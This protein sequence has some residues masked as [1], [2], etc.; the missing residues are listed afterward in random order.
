MP[1]RALKEPPITAVFDKGRNFSNCPNESIR[2]TPLEEK[3]GK[4]DSFIL[5]FAKNFENF[6]VSSRRRGATMNALFSA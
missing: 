5:I 6:S 2:Q 1:G 3:F 4:R